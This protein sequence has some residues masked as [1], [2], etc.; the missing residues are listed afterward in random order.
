MAP[1]EKRPLAHH[2]DLLVLEH[3]D[4]SIL[5]FVGVL[6]GTAV[7]A[8]QVS[9]RV[10][11]LAFPLGASPA[12]LVLDWG[13]LAAEIAWGQSDRAAGCL[14]HHPTTASRSI[15]ATGPGAWRRGCDG[16]GS[17]GC[18]CGKAGGMVD[19]ASLLLRT[20]RRLHESRRNYPDCGAA[21]VDLSRGLEWRSRRRGTS[22][23]RRRCCIG[24][25]IHHLCGRNLSA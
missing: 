15:I 4:L 25:S 1:S 17:I 11:V 19:I 9:H 10:E 23:H 13:L 21:I 5:P 2:V 18:V 7:H 16:R 24:L 12:L 20:D 8:V 3:T 22:A 14:Q 6:N